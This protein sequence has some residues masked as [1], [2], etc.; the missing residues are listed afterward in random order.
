[1]AKALGSL[2]L[3]MVLVVVVGGMPADAAGGGQGVDAAICGAIATPAEIGELVGIER[4]FFGRFD[5]VEATRGGTCRWGV[6]DEWAGPS[7]Q[8]VTAERRARG[9]CVERVADISFDCNPQ[10]TRNASAAE[11]VRQSAV[12]GGDPL[13]IGEVGLLRRS[14]VLFAH[15]GCVVTVQRLRSMDFEEGFTGAELDQGLVK[16]AEK[17]AAALDS[18]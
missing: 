5:P 2:V 10:S 17:A 11:H 7:C 12:L 13:D 14:G 8:S 9:D 3:L 16:L 18:R 4:E 15:S 1:V 6:H